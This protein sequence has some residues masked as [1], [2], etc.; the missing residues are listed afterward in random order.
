M[1]ERVERGSRLTLPPLSSSSFHVA[2]M[3]PGD[4]DRLPPLAD[5]QPLV[6][7]SMESDANYPLQ[8]DKAFM[9]RF[10]IT[11]LLSPA[12]DVWHSYYHDGA[13]RGI[14]M[15][16]KWWWE[17]V[18][19]GAAPAYLLPLSSRLLDGDAAAGVRGARGGDRLHEL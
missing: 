11:G 19:R 18:R 7:V 17:E 10:D 8:A 2:G 16:R 15:E 6:A 14:G 9:A 12:S 1:V 13:Y 4:L 3:E 5:H